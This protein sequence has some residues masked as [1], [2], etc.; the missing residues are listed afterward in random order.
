M[1]HLKLFFNTVQFE[2]VKI[3]RNKTVFIVLL[4]FTTAMLVLMSFAGDIGTGVKDRN[5]NSKIKIGINTNNVN[6]TEDVA[7]DILTDLIDINKCEKIDNIEDGIYKVNSSDL[8]LFINIEIENTPHTILVYYDQTNI[9][10][11]EMISFISQKTNGYI[12]KVTNDYLSII[13][14]KV[15]KEYFN[16]VSYEPTNKIILGQMQRVFTMATI[17]SL[18]MVIIFDKQLENCSNCFS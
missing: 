15:D 17:V 1:K 6:L 3:Y 9:V 12:E 11:N 10:A 7:G 4:L 18:V 5:Y 2:F 16:I 8:D 14:I 13:G